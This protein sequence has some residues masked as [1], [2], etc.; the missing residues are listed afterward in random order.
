MKLI[1]MHETHS[2]FLSF[3]NL[4]LQS[5]H[6]DEMRCT[7]KMVNKGDANVDHGVREEKSA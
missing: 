1:T 2:F 7:A 3:I 4:Y 6:C 5:L